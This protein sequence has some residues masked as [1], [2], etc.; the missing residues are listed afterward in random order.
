MQTH[1][2]G[3]HPVGINMVST[4]CASSNIHK[5]ESKRSPTNG[6][7][8][9]SV[10]CNCLVQG[11]VF[12]FSWPHH[13][14]CPGC[15]AL[16]SRIRL[17]VGRNLTGLANAR[18]ESRKGLARRNTKWRMGDSSVTSTGAMH[19]ASLL[20]WG[21]GTPASRKMCHMT[22]FMVLGLASGFRFVRKRQT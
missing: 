17:A 9:G 18:H 22:Q 3:N 7:K 10:V 5:A 21:L 15:P 12:M 11:E 6:C 14:P 8:R 16:R 4:S 1:W 13:Q 20:A 19:H 2:L